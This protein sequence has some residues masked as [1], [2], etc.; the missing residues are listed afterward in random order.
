M[1]QYF[2][3]TCHQSALLAAKIL[4]QT[5]SKLLIFFYHFLRFQLNMSPPI[6]IYLYK[7]ERYF[8]FVINFSPF[9]YV[10]SIDKLPGL[11]DLSVEN[12]RY[13]ADYG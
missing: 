3:T 2:L 1:S 11:Q 7:L 12:D 10:N 4:P 6:G 8:V 5:T 13:L 9:K